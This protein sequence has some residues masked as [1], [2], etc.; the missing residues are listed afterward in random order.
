M[1]GVARSLILALCLLLVSGCSVVNILKLRNANNNVEPIWSHSE[2][3][4]NLATDYIGEKVFIYGAING[5]DG[6]KFMIDTG[7]SFTYL[8][9]TPKVVALNLPEGYELN[10][11]GWGDEDD[12]LGHQTNMMSLKFG[13]MAVED[14]QGAFLRM[15]KTRYFNSSDELIYDGIIGHDLLRHFVWT[16]DKKT[17]QV[18]ISNKPHS[19]TDGIKGL[20]FD[21]FMSKISI[22]G[23]IDFGN[24]HNVEHEFIIDTGSRHYFK[25]S[26]EYPKANGIELPNAQVTAADFG[27]SG[28]AEHQRVTLPQIEFGDTQITKI[29]T[30]IINTDDEDD[31]WIIGNGTLNQFV[32]TIDYQTSNIYMQ[33]YEN[34]PFQSRYN[35]L[36]LEVRKLLS[37][38]FLV[39][40][41]MPALPAKYAGLNVGD[42]ITQINGVSAKDISKDEWL[43]ISATPGNYKICRQPYDCLPLQSRHIKGYSN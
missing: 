19:V 14:F 22:V 3:Q 9:D 20:P 39:R 43:S 21:T 12:S 33:P 6:F 2:D 10:L 38:E 16:F 24:G 32:T 17:N 29:K 42:I 5:V 15:S 11:G 13:E 36:G 18:S 34:Q 8:M 40:Y 26:S 28:K 25:L 1:N 37:G 35:L 31:Y 4:F 23:N 30:N 41:V 7:A 27:L